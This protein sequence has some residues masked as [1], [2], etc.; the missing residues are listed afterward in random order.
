MDK[1]NNASV[2]TGNENLD[3]LRRVFPQFVKENK[4]DFE[5]LNKFFRD[6]EIIAGEEKYGLNWAGKS[7]AFKLIRTP[8]V[9][10]LTP[11]EK[12]SKDWD[13]TENLFIEGDNLE[14]LKLLQKHYREKI[15][16]IYIDPPYN[17][18][19]DFIYKDNYTENISD[20]Y[21][22]TGQSKNGI[23]MTTNPESAGRYHSDW[24]TMM[25]PR[26]FLARNLLKEDGVIFISVDDNEVANLR[27]IM[28]E[29]FGEE[30][31]VAQI[32]WQNKEGGGGSDSRLFK[33]KHEYVLCYGKAVD[34][35]DIQGIKPNNV[36]RYTESD[37]YFNTRGKHLLIK[38]ES[39][40]LG[41]I[42]S[43]DYPILAPDGIEI[44]PNQDNQKIKRWRWSKEK[45]NWGIKNDYIVIKKDQNKNW[46]VYT[47]QYLNADNEGNIVER[48]QN[49]VAVVDQFSTTQSAKY[50]AELFGKR[51]FDYPKPMELIKW[52][53][54]RI[55][56]KKNDIVLDFFAGSGTTA[57][58][59]MELNAE[60]GGD[61]KWI[62]VQLPEATNE[63]SEAYKA[64]YKNIAEIA[65]ERIRRVASA[66]ATA[67]QGGKK[68]D[69]GFKSISLSKSNYRQWNILTDK[70]DEKKLKDQMKIFLEKPLVDGY[71]EK[72]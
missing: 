47:K 66:I 20:Y 65:R 40:S 2:N 64:R 39:G 63:D 4:I 60:D 59:V 50:L 1:V 43:L 42:K 70:D 9:G 67:S 23:K 21:E 34:L 10:T 41:Y 26:L 45:F 37:K 54:D 5:A 12:E 48:R 11:Q 30:N 31:F 68:F 28:D 46:G 55:I 7:N 53:L 58:A 16:M 3:K 36:E 52:L 22:K 24:L 8:S 57:H 18:G 25:Y 6:E 19:K 29:I 32:V 62:C 72:S 15:K 27:L 69:L 35:L 38:L 33:I 71:D 49:P 17:T 13:R 14:V 51:I 44:Y 56:S 61:R